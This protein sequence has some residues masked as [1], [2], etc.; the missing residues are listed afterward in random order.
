[1]RNLQFFRRSHSHHKRCFLTLF[2][3]L[4]LNNNKL[5][6]TISPQIDNLNL[7]EHIYLGQNSFNGTLPPN[8][9][10]NRPNNW[11]FFSVYDNKLTGPIPMN[12]R[13]RNAYQL[14]FSRNQL[15]G[16]IPS[17]INQ[18]NYSKL[19]MLYVGHN[20]LIGNIPSTHLC[21]I[22]TTTFCQSLAKT[23]HIASMLTV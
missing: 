7:A 8:I 4:Y 16:E 20:R 21:L 5:T 19:R 23:H 15:E 11:R 18:E 1:M 13:L 6:G 22:L 10:T 3:H 2:R 12:M 9:G 17:D 14:D